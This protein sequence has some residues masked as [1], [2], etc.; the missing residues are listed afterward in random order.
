MHLKSPLSW[1]SRASLL[2]LTLFHCAS[3][4]FAQSVSQGTGEISGRVL[5]S[6]NG[7]YVEL[8]RVTVDG[9]LLET[10]TDASGSYHLVNVP[11]GTVTVRVFHTGSADQTAKVGVTPGQLS[12]QDFTLTA[13]APRTGDGGVVKLGEFVV[14]STRQMDMAAM[15]INTQRFA[16]NLMN[17]VASDEFGGAA[18]SKV[19]EIIK[20]LPSVSMTLG[21]GG[22]PYQVSI[23]GV[24]ANNVPV[25]I[26]GFNLATSLPGTS[27]GVGLHQIAINTISRLEVIHTPTPESPGAAL[28]GSVNLVPRNAFER[29]KPVY[30]LSAFLSM[31][32]SERSLN[33]TPGPLREPTTKVRPGLEFSAIVPVNKRFGF[34]V[35]ASASTLYRVQDFLQSAWRGTGS[36]TNGTTFADTTPDNPYLSD[37]S[38][39]DGGA[40]VTAQ[41]FGATLDFQ[42]S[43]TDQ[44]NFV[45]QAAY[46]DFAQSTRQLTFFTN[47]VTAGNFTATSTKG[48]KDRGEIR[49]TNTSNDLNSNLFMPTLSYRHNGPIWQAEAGIGHSQSLYR[50][51]D[52]GNGYFFRSQARRRN[53]TVAFDGISYLR[54][55]TIT[56]TDGTSGA[57][58]DPYLLSNYTLV[59]ATPNQFDAIDIQQTAYANLRRTFY[60]A[61]PFTVKAGLD[62][63]RQ[64]RDHTNPSSTLT[65]VGKDGT[66]NSPDDNATVIFDDLFSQRTA[67]YGFPRVQWTSNE[68]LFDLYKSAPNYFTENLTSAYT[69][70]V[71]TSRHASE[72]ISSAFVRVDAQFLQRRLKMTGGL[73]VEQTNV[74]AEGLLVDAT[75]NFQRDSAGNVILGANGQPVPITTDPLEAAHLTNIERG[76]HAKKEYL[77]WF[78][79]INANYTIRDN[80]IARIGYYWSVGRPDFNQYGGSATLPNTENPPGP[81]NRITIG[82]ASIKAW[83]ARTTKVSL[84]YYFEPVGLLSV[85][86]FQRDCENLFG[87]TVFRATPE[88]LSL[89]SINP[90]LYGDY[91]VSTQYNIPNTVHSTGVALNYKQALNFLPDWARGIRVFANLSS[92]RITDD[93][94]GSFTGYTPRTANWGISL[95]RERFTTRINWNYTGRKRLGPIASGRS[96]PTDAY[97]WDVPRLIVDFSAEYFLNKTFTLYAN[98]NNLFDE[99]VDREIY[100]TA[101]PEYARLRQRQN[102]GALWTFGI[103][104][105]F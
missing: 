66:A 45:F 99:P 12:E 100:G 72:L 5:N 65:F 58:I 75:R 23:D 10:Y 95:S 21:G 25:T 28:A 98:M 79:S 13:R 80:L 96:I 37:F 52:V 32:D 36:T 22:E 90:T 51:L 53:V 77:R 34:T 42:L 24:P 41:S 18:E 61:I 62:F 83:T 44:L 81:T 57:P 82:N 9:T 11:R 4:N 97:N 78:P 39:R 74:D 93:T 2:C 46:S 68:A 49:I 48:T 19:G 89:Y 40:M 30:T 26:G 17:V 8:A 15:V 104:G 94:S 88:F 87:S 76:L 43:R 38:V 70:S 63:R 105:T 55:E 14:A 92:Q 3:F 71:A 64:K 31:R 101:T 67:P 85:S 6:S 103:K 56:V 91:D 47:G 69:Q 60:G 86:A 54:P 35:S 29:A 102:F 7:E 16:P 59:D 73:R 84:E 50:R 33:R 27:R 1:I 20:S